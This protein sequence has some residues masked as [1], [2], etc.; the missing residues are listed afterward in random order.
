M[1]LDQLL[2]FRR[3]CQGAW[4]VS[5][6]GGG[7]VCCQPFGKRERLEGGGGRLTRVIALAE[8]RAQP[9]GADFMAVAVQNPEGHVVL[10]GDDDRLRVR[11][12]FRARNN[13]GT[14]TLNRPSCLVT[15][16][17]GPPLRAA[18]ECSDLAG[19]RSLP[20]GPQPDAEEPFVDPLSAGVANAVQDHECA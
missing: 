14:F 1:Q 16:T 2:S 8:P 6:V 9:D 20:A 12:L 4:I 13:Q 17:L 18:P 19:A 5:E 11:C 15:P 3:Y 7:H 10:T